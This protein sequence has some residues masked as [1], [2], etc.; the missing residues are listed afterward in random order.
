MRS[1]EKVL[2]QFFIVAIGLVFLIKLFFIQVLDNT[3]KKAADDNIIQKI[4][5]Y[6][7]RGLIEDRN[8]ELLVYNQPIYDLQIV[9]REIQ[10][11]DTARFCE[12]FGITKQQFV[13]KYQEALEYSYVKPSVFI[14]QIS[15]SDFASIQD[16]L[17][18]Y[19]GFYVTA[20][21][22]RAYSR[23]IFANAL[24][25]IGEIDKKRLSDD[26]SEYYQQGDY[27]GISGI[28]ASYEPWLRGKRG[29]SVRMVNAKGEEK[30]SFKDGQLDTKPVPGENLMSTIDLDLQLYAE[31]LLNNKVGSIVAI[32]PATGEI[33]TMATAPTYD[34][35]ILT[36]RNFSQNFAKLQIDTLV[37]LFNRP[38]MADVYPPGST[39]KLLQTLIGLEEGVIAP[40]TEF[41][42]NQ[43]IIGCHNHG[44]RE[45]L[46]GAIRNSCNPYFFNVFRRIINQSPEE[47]PY[48]DARIGLELWRQHL[49]SFG[50]GRTLGIDLPNEKPGIIPSVETY[51]KMYGNERWKFSN[52]YS[53]AIGQGE[54]G[55]SP[56]QMANFVTV[57]ANRGFYYPPHVIKSVGI[58]NGK[59]ADFKEKKHSSI[60]PEH[61]VLVVEAMQ[62]V[63]QR[64][65]GQYRAKLKDLTVCGKTGT[66]QNPHGED[67]SVFLAFAPKE[68]PQI[69]VSVYVENAGQGAR[70]AAAISGLLIEKYLKGGGAE[71]YFEEYVLRGEFLH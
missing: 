36:G 32:E 28:E 18:D 24:G 15:H 47:S 46:L 63:V 23:P 59:L 39:F 12:I 29:E 70:A 40:L 2:I 64:G 25:Y 43:S 6:P 5:E 4:I 19:K 9:P 56:L 66:I 20:R 7:Y 22:V 42:C 35:T 61:F 37:P 67:H 71:L 65:T 31:K 55:V 13:D 48:K 54:L 45:D 53:L 57:I 44:P 16:F 62:E 49:L 1:N 51:D 69:A 14:K 38:I 33:L 21:T 68:N 50:L 17:V 41:D 10:V 60:S 30:G 52:I 58:N 11:P 8:G 34:P 26:S 27:I 3:Y